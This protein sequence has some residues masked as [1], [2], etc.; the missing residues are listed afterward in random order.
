MHGLTGNREDTWKRDGILWP[1][2]L[3]P[4]RLPEARIMTFGYDANVIAFLSAAS[5]NRIASHGQNLLSSLA[6]V[7]D[8]SETVR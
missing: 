3:L 7:R 8:E 4:K 5:Q 2:D 6:D 1:Q